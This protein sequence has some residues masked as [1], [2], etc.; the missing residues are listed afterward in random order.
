MLVRCHIHG[1]GAH[2]IVPHCQV[3][4]AKKK[5]SSSAAIP[6]SSC[7]CALRSAAG[8]DLD[9]FFS[10]I[11]RIGRVHKETIHIRLVSETEPARISRR[12]AEIRSIRSVDSEIKTFE[13]R[14]VGS[15][16]GV[17]VDDVKLPPNQWLPLK[18][19]SIIGFGGRCIDSSRRGAAEFQYRFVSSLVAPGPPARKRVRLCLD[20]KSS[21]PS[22]A[23]ASSSPP[24]SS[25]SLQYPPVSLLN[26]GSDSSQNIAIVPSHTVSPSRRPRLPESDSAEIAEVV[27]V[28][29]TESV[30]S[31]SNESLDALDLIFANNLTCEREKQSAAPGPGPSVTPK[32]LVRRIEIDIE[33]PGPVVT[34][35]D[36]PPRQHSPVDIEIDMKKPHISALVDLSSGSES[37]SADSC[38]VTVM[39]HSTTPGRGPAPGG[40]K[41][42]IKRRI[43]S[44]T[45]ASSSSSSSSSS[46]LCT[47]CLTDLP[48]FIGTAAQQ[49]HVSTCRGPGSMCPM[50]YKSFHSASA[51]SDHVEVCTGPHSAPKPTP[52]R[53]RK[54]I[55]IAPL[56]PNRSVCPFCHRAI[57]KTAINRHAEVCEAERGEDVSDQAQLFQLGL[58]RC[59]LC[60]EP[61][62]V[63]E[64]EV[65]TA[66]CEKKLI[67][68]SQDEKVAISLARDLQL[69]EILTPCQ[70][71]AVSHVAQCA[72][73]LH[74]K[75][76]PDLVARLETLGYTEITLRK[77]LSF[78]RYTAPIV[79][80]VNLG[81]VLK[82]FVQDTHYRNLFEVKRSGGSSNI[83]SRSKWE[84]NI[85][86]S[87]YED[88]VPFERPK[89]GVLNIL[90]DPNGVASC[91]AY[92]KSYFRLRADR[93]N[94]R[95]TFASE[96]TSSSSVRLASLEWYAHILQEYT[97]EELQQVANIALGR[98]ISHSST[99][100]RKY[101]E[102]QIH[103]E[104][105][106]DRDIEALVVYQS[107]KRQ[108]HLVKLLDDFSHQHPNVRVVWMKDLLRSRKTSKS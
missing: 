105:A 41:R 23:P 29:D 89:Y 47:K 17:F 73:V 98:E 27:M 43:A 48:P 32:D 79:I 45:A 4:S 33:A 95:S 90:C 61:I 13:I 9:Q 65:H 82:H 22:H 70:L 53:R 59:V 103:G 57:L 68:M 12:H 87:A 36:N 80:H 5:P 72:K 99:L 11:I 94:L 69:S 108:G 51:L 38:T 8:I 18:D 63:D 86:N 67:A 81:I 54:R 104:V 15:V 101:K 1:S 58:K 42:G 14:D 76:L 62:M 77:I 31:E 25:P 92:G 97:N 26:I 66:E 107:V 88:A 78:I 35:L 46:I 100:F 34:V 49:L 39:S 93:V 83:K 85:F 37:D 24:S 64:L 96:D 21:S 3:K 10:N 30:L 50:C 55:P 56:D 40:T 102:V 71:T 28:N 6:S 44:I 2:H 60:N 74:E 75:A 84:N 7:D 19:N 16:N 106:I 52:V 20:T 91:A